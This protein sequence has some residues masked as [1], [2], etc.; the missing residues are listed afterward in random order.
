MMMSIVVNESAK[1]M[2]V[3][4]FYTIVT[5][6]RSMLRSVVLVSF[7]QTFWFMFRNYYSI[8][9]IINNTTFLWRSSKFSQIGQNR[10]P[11]HQKRVLVT[12]MI[13]TVFNSYSYSRIDRAR[14]TER[15]I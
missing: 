6:S 13:G 15:E 12:F 5:L 4:V 8:I 3:I 9:T 1:N 14:Q 10:K 11:K 2:P 7:V